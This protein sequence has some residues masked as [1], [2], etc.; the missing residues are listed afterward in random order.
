MMKTNFKKEMELAFNL[1]DVGKP[2]YITLE[3]LERICGQLNMD[4]TQEE[5]EKMIEAGS[6]ADPGPNKTREKGKVFFEQFV[7]MMNDS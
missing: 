6:Q 2:S 4:F 7:L 5:I 1:I 3:E